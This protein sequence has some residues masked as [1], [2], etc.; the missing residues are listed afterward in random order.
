MMRV[1][2]VGSRAQRGSKGR[3]ST[4]DKEEDAHKVVPSLVPREDHCHRPDVHLKLPAERGGQRLE[5]VGQRDC[6]LPRRL[7]LG[8]EPGGL[9]KVS[10]R[11]LAIARFEEQP[12][13]EVVQ[14][15]AGATDRHRESEQ[16]LCVA[17]RP[18]VSQHV[19]QLGQR[20]V[21]LPVGRELQRVLQAGYCLGSVSSNP[22]VDRGE[23]GEHP[24]RGVPLELPR[25]PCPHLAV[26]DLESQ[27]HPIPRSQAQ[28]LLWWERRA[29]S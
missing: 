5:H 15:V 18:R 22:P 20:H 8:F 27:F 9:E 26:G 21:F 1:G 10:P 2:R 4:R 13:V 24:G 23:V 6:H 7:Q 25:N 29:G 16:H 12:P 17:A 11:P 28:P 19:G 14:G 3:T